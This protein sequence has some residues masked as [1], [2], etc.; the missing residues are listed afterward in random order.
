M[1]AIPRLITYFCL[2]IVLGLSLVACGPS[3]L[4]Y[5]SYE[6]ASPVSKPLSDAPHISVALFE[7]SR[8]H[9][10]LGIKKSGSAFTSANLVA[11]W[12]TRS[13][14]DELVRRG[15]NATYAP[16]MDMALE[17]NPQ[18]L[19]TGIVHDVWLEEITTTTYKTTIRL[20]IR[21]SDLHGRLHTETI[22]ASQE[23]TGL[24][25]S[26]VANIL[27]ANTLQDLLVPASKKLL[28][29]LR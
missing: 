25:T 18:Y 28:T 19:M 10:N 14:T 12:I 15:A 4:V 9:A 2:I 11:E 6:P 5:L 26:E 23:F 21:L 17:T 16:T 29:T 3:N 24:P 13:L 27:F 22:N 8:S 7:D 20:T 1:Y